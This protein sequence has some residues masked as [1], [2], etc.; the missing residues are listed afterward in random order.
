MSLPTAEEVLHDRVGPHIERLV[1]WLKTPHIQTRIEA[2]DLRWIIARLIVVMELFL[3][4]DRLKNGVLGQVP[5]SQVKDLL[6]ALIFLFFRDELN[7]I[8]G[9]WDFEW[10]VRSTESELQAGEDATWELADGYMSIDHETLRTTLRVNSKFPDANAVL[11]TFLHE[12]VHIFIY[13]S[14]VR[15]G[16]HTETHENGIAKRVFRKQ[17]GLSGHGY[18]FQR[19][20]RAV[21][22]RV[23]EI[24][25][26]D[27][28]LGRKQALFEEC[29]ATGIVPDLE[30]LEEMFGGTTSGQDDTPE[31]LWVEL[32]I[33]VYCSR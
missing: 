18:Y 8:P 17:N 30:Y 9:P 4:S 13:H 2:D 16:L 15:E 24:L 31:M 26:V 1:Q 14:M 27:I 11:G 3:M 25:S 21:E 5:W 19:L 12:L 29:E 23:R 20:A 22:E 28:D 6:W 33:K 32:S 7:K 10:L